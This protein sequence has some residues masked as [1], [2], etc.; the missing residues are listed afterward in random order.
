MQGFTFQDVARL[1]FSILEEPVYTDVY[2]FP[3]S[4]VISVQADDQVECKISSLSYSLKGL[5][6]SLGTGCKYNQEI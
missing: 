1:E 5:K 3:I 6:A 2:I 4:T